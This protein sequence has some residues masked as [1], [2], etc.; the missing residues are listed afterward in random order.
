MAADDIHLVG[1]TGKKLSKLLQLVS[2]AQDEIILIGDDQEKDP[3]FYKVVQTQFPN[4]IKAIYIHQLNPRTLPEGQIGFFTA[5]EL[6]LFETQAG[7]L[8]SETPEIVR[9]YIE[10]KLDQA[11]KYGLGRKRASELLIPKWQ[12]CS[13]EVNERVIN[14]ALEIQDSNATYFGRLISILN[15]NCRY[16]ELELTKEK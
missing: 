11:A 5:Y 8:P 10:L 13:K 14:G 1:G 16:N 7:R 15:K 4:K 12:K 2:E 6:A 3:D 9:S